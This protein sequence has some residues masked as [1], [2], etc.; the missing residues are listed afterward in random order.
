MT[1]SQRF[2]LASVLSMILA[3]AAGATTIFTPPV[4]PDDDGN[5]FCLV[6]NVSARPVTVM[7]DVSST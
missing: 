4:V 7:I 2:L 6:T 5:F 1:L 3:A